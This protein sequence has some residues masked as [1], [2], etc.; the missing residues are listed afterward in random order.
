M[1]A[2]TI[3]IKPNKLLNNFLSEKGKVLNS[4]KVYPKLEVAYKKTN[5]LY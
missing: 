2:G 3:K 4:L 5:K 1:C